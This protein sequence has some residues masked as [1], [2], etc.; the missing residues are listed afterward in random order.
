MKKRALSA[1]FS[2]PAEGKVDITRGSREERL[3]A[4]ANIVSLAKEHPKNILKHSGDS[5]APTIRRIAPSP[6]VLIIAK[7]SGK[8]EKPE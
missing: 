8:I 2:E 6:F 4:C 7:K 5:A 1:I 3:S